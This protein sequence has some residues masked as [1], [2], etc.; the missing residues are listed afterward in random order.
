MANIQPVSIWYQGLDHQANVFSLY[1]TG[2][3]LIDYA[4]FQYQLIEEIVISPEEIKS[5]IL[6]IGVLNIS[7]EDYAQ[8]DAEVDANAWIYQWAANQL[9]LVLIPEISIPKTIT[10]ESE[11][12]IGSN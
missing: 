5:Q 1:S 3:N 9:N 2:D 11:T 10:N 6:I 4:T 7:G 12:S 8:W